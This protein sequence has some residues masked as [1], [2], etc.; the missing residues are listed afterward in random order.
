MADAR[1]LTVRDSSGAP[2]TTGVTF[3]LYLNKQTG[4]ARTQPALTHRGDG[5]WVFT[6]S[7]DDEA[8]GTLALL[9]AGSAL[10]RRALFAIH[11]ADNSNQ[12][13]AFHYEDGAGSLYI[14]SGAGTPGT[15]Q[16]IDPAGNART[17]PA[18]A[19]PANPHLG[20]VAIYTLTPTPA[21]VAAGIEL[22]LD[23]PAA[24]AFPAYWESSSLPVVTSGEAT[25]PV[26]SNVTPASGTPIT[27]D[28]AIGFDVTDAGG[29]LARSNVHVWYPSLQRFETIYFGAISG[30]WGSRGE[31]F[32]PQ[33]AGTRTA[34]TNGF[35]FADV[36]R[37]GG[38]PARPVIVVDAVDAVG[39]EAA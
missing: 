13:W 18:F 29:N 24:G 26:V 7:D 1:S 20:V 36:K 22:R 21:D 25:I 9:S 3:F 38:W 14:G 37:R 35:R 23:A 16:Y 19:F 17:P 4:A 2:V 11:K 15:L 32:G 5:K 28:T 34:I 6:P 30:A 10:P 31:G 39:N 27:P 33:Y 12:F 8:V